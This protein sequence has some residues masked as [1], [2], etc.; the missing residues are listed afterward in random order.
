MKKE[1]NFV[2]VM[3]F[4]ITR[5]LCSV[6]PT[7][8]KQEIFFFFFISSIFGKRKFKNQFKP[9]SSNQMDARLAVDAAGHRRFHSVETI[10]SISFLISISLTCQYHIQLPIIRV[11]QAYHFR[12]AFDG[13]YPPLCCQVFV[14]AANLALFPCSEEYLIFFLALLSLSLHLIFF[15]VFC[16]CFFLYKIKLVIYLQNHFFWFC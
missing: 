7:K 12:L 8:K 13:I 1:H 5:W 3:Q 15:F 14:E 9:Q 2:F 16:C 4:W 10:T 6:K 11:D